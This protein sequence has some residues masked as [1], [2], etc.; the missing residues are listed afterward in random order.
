MQKGLLHNQQH[1]KQLPLRELAE[2]HLQ[3]WVQ[4]AGEQEVRAGL[5]ISKGLEPLHF[6]KRQPLTIDDY[7]QEEEPE[8][9]KERWLERQLQ[10]KQAQERRKQEWQQREKAAEERRRQ[11]ELEQTE[12]QQQQVRNREQWDQGQWDQ[13]QLDWE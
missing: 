12:W 2:T 3:Q 8:Q 1:R 6:H 9:L 5:S 10:W 7:F 4:R 13:E 11:T